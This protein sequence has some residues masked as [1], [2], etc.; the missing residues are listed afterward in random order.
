MKKVLLPI[1][2]VDYFATEGRL[3]NFGKYLSDQ[4]AVEFL[5]ISEKVLED[6]K[7]KLSACRN[8]TVE[9]IE[10]GHIELPLD[11]RTNLVKIFI[12]YTNDLL[13]PDTDLKLWKTAATD[14]FWGHLSSCSFGE[15]LHVD[16]DIALLPLLS[17]DDAPSDTVDVFYTSVICR[18]KN[19]GIKVVGYQ[20]YPVF[21]GLKLMPLLMDA[22]LVKKEY[23]RQF[24]LD[25]GIPSDSIYLLTD[26]R[27]RYSINSISDLYENYRYNEQIAISRDELSIV[28]INHTKFRPFIRQIIKAVGELKVPVVLSLLKRV[29]AVKELKEDDIIAEFYLGDIEKTGCRFY[30]LEP[31]SVTPVI[32]I[33]DVTIAC[34]FVAP[35]ELAARY[36]KKA[37]VYNPFYDA[38]ADVEGTVFINDPDALLKALKRAYK[39]KKMTVGAAEAINAILGK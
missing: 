35:V 31:P 24:Y 1:S 36:G 6:I 22:I 8:I 10:P 13:I 12:R 23:E 28:I 29:Y 38:V 17:Y 15:D 21:S 2:E 25:M 32:M 26:A 14:D 5:T 37:I 7:Q 4:F 30:L 11:F 33:S 16:C 27:D 19:A 34:T 39:E 3:F 18:L 20:L 9:F